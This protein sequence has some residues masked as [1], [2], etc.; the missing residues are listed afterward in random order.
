MTMADPRTVEIFSA[1]CPI[2]DD[3]V[4]RVREIACESCDVQVL[5]LNNE[6]VAQRATDLG[7]RAV[8]AV[9]VNGELAAC[10]TDRGVDRATLEAT[11]IG[12]P[13]N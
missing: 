9:A 7:I 13:L 5:D 8:P 11:G 3:V 4:Q 12:Q 2:C 6:A 1:G 10:C